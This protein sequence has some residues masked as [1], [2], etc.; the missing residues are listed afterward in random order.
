MGRIEEFLKMYSAE[1][2]R[3]TYRTAIFDF[4]DHVYG[5]IRKGKR[6]RKE[7]MEKYEEAA[8]NYFSEPRDF[9]KDFLSFVSSVDEAPTGARAKI[10]GVKEFLIF[11]G[12]EFTQKQLRQIR[13]KMPKGKTARTAEK[14]IDHEVLRKVLMHTDV[15]G[16]ALILTLASSGMRIGECLQVKLSDVDL[17]K[18]PARIVVRG[19]HTKSGDTRTVFVSKEAKQA[20]KEWLKVRSSYLR[21]AANRNK[22][23]GGSKQVEDERLFPFSYNTANEIWENALK[24]AGLLEKDASTGWNRYRIH[25]LRKFFRSQLALAC[26]VEIVEALM[27]HE[28]YLTEAYRRYTINQMAEYYKKA[29]HLVTIQIPREIAEIGSEFRQEL[30]KNRKLIEDLI[31]ENR[32]FRRKNAELEER[33]KKVEDEIKMANELFKEIAESGMLL[34]LREM[35]ELVKA[36]EEDPELRKRL[37]DLGK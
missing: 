20:L 12:I 23:L 2:T 13:G 14:D 29:E 3:R 4:L 33:L 21:S 5:R 31:I 9:F 7:E 11:N 32:E 22:G 28:G 16:K 26:P 1:A 27:G 15:K 8:E 37:M 18:E 35:F 36:M 17:S 10:N 34:R 30:D 25:G 24:K 6:V 19:E